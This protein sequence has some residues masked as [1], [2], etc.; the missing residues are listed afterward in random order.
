MS[1]KSPLCRRHTQS[2]LS[3][4]T[5]STSDECKYSPIST[6]KLSRC[7]LLERVLVRKRKERGIQCNC[8]PV[9]SLYRISDIK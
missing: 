4:L 3:Y 1:K 2:T 6:N 7:P 8:C 9:S 5:F